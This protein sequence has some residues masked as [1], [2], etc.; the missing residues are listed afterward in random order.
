MPIK[1]F[2][3]RVADYYTILKI[4]NDNNERWNLWQQMIH[5]VIQTHRNMVW[6]PYP[7]LSI[8]K[9]PLLVAKYV[10]ILR[11]TSIS[12]KNKTSQKP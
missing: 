1:P 2:I 8:E 10:C 6:F 12:T 9:G 7:L 3:Q 4:D 11:Q 5:S